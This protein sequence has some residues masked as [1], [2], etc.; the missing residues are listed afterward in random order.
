MTNI[1]RKHGRVM[2]IASKG[3]GVLLIIVG[4]MLM[5]GTFELLARW[6]VFVDFGL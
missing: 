4:V 5:T 3:M 1:L 6:G 2:E